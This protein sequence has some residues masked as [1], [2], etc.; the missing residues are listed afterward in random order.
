LLKEAKQGGVLI[1]WVAVR[2]C[3]YKKTA[4]KDYQAV[5]DPDKPL[6]NMMEADR[7][8]A[9]VRIC[10]EIEKAVNPSNTPV[11]EDSSRYA[12]SHSAPPIVTPPVG[13]KPQLPAEQAAPARR[14]VLPVIGGILAA[15]IVA[16]IILFLW[17]LN[18]PTVTGAMPPT[19]IDHS[20]S[21]FTVPRLF[22]AGKPQ[23]EYLLQN[24]S[25]LSRALSSA[26]IIVAIPRILDDPGRGEINKVF[27]YHPHDQEVAMRVA[28]KVK[29][30]LGVELP[31][32]ALGND[33]RAT[34]GY[35]EIWIAKI[36]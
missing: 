36:P 4:L 24:L 27:Y 30:A 2:A 18:K 21:E 13:Q 32:V 17:N 22:A 8:Q 16:S 6:A 14:N 29:D 1:L 3:S 7:D 10:E 12:T 19:P 23:Q 35:F 20:Q 15:M 11:P 5:L 28:Q 25:K 26:G 31:A 33:D 9:W 34:P